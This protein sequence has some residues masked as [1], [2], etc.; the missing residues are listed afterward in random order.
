MTKILPRRVLDLFCGAGGAAMGLHR[1]WPDAKITGVDIKPQKNYP[2]NFVQADAMTF[3]LDGYNFIWASPPCQRYTRVWRGQLHKRA[4][5][6]DLIDPVRNKLAGYPL[7]VIENVPGAPLRADAVLCGSQFDLDIVRVRIFELRGFTVPFQLVR[8][9]SRI[10]SDGGL[11]CVAGH[12]ANNAYNLRRS[13][14]LCKWRDL[15]ADLKKRLLERNCAKGWADAMGIDWMTRN[16]IREA[17]PP[18]Y[19]EFI[20]RQ[21]PSL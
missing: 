10:V 20:A 5:Y 11:A 15:P 8:P 1:A 14:G 12:G 19:S 16:E 17:V 18:A 3:D 7:S 2:F 4:N 9:Q 21:V 6:P 13:R